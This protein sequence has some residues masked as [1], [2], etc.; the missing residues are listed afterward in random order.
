M[1]AL[2]QCTIGNMR[3]SKLNFPCTLKKLE[4]LKIGGLG[5]QSELIFENLQNTLCLT[6]K[7]HFNLPRAISSNLL[8]LAITAGNY[9]LYFGSDYDKLEELTINDCPTSITWPKKFDSL[10][11]ACS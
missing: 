10:K 1:N 5:P 11:K 9:N 2:K 7:T 3:H 8:N 4:S 6:E